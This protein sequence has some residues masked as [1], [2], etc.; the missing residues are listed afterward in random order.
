MKRLAVIV[1]LIAF[2]V[3]AI[4]GAAAGLEDSEFRVGLYPAYHLGGGGATFSVWTVGWT[5]QTGAPLLLV[6]FGLTFANRVAVT[7]TSSM[8]G[9]QPFAFRGWYFSV[10]ASL[11]LVQVPSTA[12]TDWFGEIGL[13]VTIGDGLHLTIGYGSAAWLNVGVGLT[14]TINDLLGFIRRNADRPLI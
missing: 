12:G 3:P 6:D 8:H 13:M 10:Y 9:D 4:Q 5:H 1:V 14:A 11:G 2:V 7:M